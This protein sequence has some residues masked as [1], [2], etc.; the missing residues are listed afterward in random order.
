MKHSTKNFVVSKG[1]KHTWTCAQNF[2]SLKIIVSVR[3]WLGQI[4]LIFRQN[5]DEWLVSQNV[6]KINFEISRIRLFR[7]NFF[8]PGRNPIIH[9]YLSLSYSALPLLCLYL[10]QFFNPTKLFCSFITVLVARIT[11]PLPEY[12]LCED[13]FTVII[14]NLKLLAQLTSITKH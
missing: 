10:Y 6:D 4:L 5:W 2:C 11:G 14:L 7:R 13:I 8:C 3:H 12:Y 9:V 1:L